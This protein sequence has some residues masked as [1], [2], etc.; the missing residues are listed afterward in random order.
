MTKDKMLTEEGANREAANIFP[1]TDGTA[2]NRPK[3]NEQCKT[4]YTKDLREMLKL[5]KAKAES[6]M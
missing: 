2:M 1:T 5:A 3:Y 4:D 6:N